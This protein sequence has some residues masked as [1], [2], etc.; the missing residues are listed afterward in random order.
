MPDFLMPA[1]YALNADRLRAYVQAADAANTRTAYANDLAHFTAWGGSLPS[2][3]QEVAAYLS[4]HAESL[5][6][7]TLKRR[8][9][10]LSR[11]HAALNATN[12]TQHELVRLTLRGIARTH[13]KPARKLKPLVK[14]DILRLLMP[15]DRSLRG[16]RNQAL[17]LITFAG[18]F[19]RS[20]VVVLRLENLTFQREGV[21]I[22]LTRSKTDQE[23]KGRQVAIPFGRGSVCPVKAL[24]TWLETAN[25]REGLVFRQVAKGSKLGGALSPKAVRELVREWSSTAG[26]DA[27]NLG[28][29]SLRAGMVTSAAQAGV[30]TH[31]IMAQTGHRSVE[32]MQGYIRDSDIFNQNAAGGLF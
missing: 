31:K 30:P 24:T 10:G 21:V 12:P 6:L 19:R 14:E 16:L 28:A 32:V 23:G 5:A 7:A 2:T 1:G 22:T 4:A 18:G 29:H 8:L 15:M 13:G 17:L 27:S 11:A 26:L 20:E 25:I 9:V 3:P